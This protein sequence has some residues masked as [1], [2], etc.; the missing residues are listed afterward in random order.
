VGH[1][2]FEPGIAGLRTRRSGR[3]PIVLCPMSSRLSSLNPYPGDYPG[4]RALLAK[5]RPIL[6]KY[7]HDVATQWR[8]GS[9]PL[10]QC[11][12]THT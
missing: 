7:S 4:F 1:P 3:L 12:V 6:R 8:C 9:K 10:N 11:I 5:E 2:G